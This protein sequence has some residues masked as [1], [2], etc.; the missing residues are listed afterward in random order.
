[1]N[2]Q[3]MELLINRPL[4]TH[5]SHERPEKIQKSMSH[6]ERSLLKSITCDNGEKFKHLSEDFPC[7][8]IYYTHPYSASGRGANER[9]NGLVRY[10]IPK[11]TRM[12]AISDEKVKEIEA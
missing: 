6:R 4:F 1:M 11:G 5:T 3:F 8:K 7:L 9:Q 10:F 2:L 12:R